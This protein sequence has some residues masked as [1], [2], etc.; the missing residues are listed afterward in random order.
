LT[1]ILDV[2]LYY[3]LCWP[4]YMYINLQ[5][6]YSNTGK[7]G[8]PA[9]CADLGMVVRRFL[10]RSRVRRLLQV[11]T[12]MAGHVLRL[13]PARDSTSSLHRKSYNDHSTC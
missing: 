13:F 10:E 2:N 1:D 11:V 8:W 3:T 9:C 4:V 7:A 12:S 5:K 6:Y